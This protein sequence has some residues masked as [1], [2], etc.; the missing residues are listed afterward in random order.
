MYL[1]C[2]RIGI[3]IGGRWQSFDS[4]DAVG[5]VSVSRDEGLLVSGPVPGTSQTDPT[6]ASKNSCSTMEQ[7]VKDCILQERP[8]AKAG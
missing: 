1:I 2:L 5:V 8:N 7:F 4:G 6:Q 3:C